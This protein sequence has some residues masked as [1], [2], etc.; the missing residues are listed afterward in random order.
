MNKNKSGFLHLLPLILIGVLIA[1]VGGYFWYQQNLNKVLV[2]EP[3]PAPIIS[4]IPTSS[5]EIVINTDDWKTFMGEGFSFKYPQRFS[6]VSDDQ[7]VD[8]STVVK[9]TDKP[10]D[11][12]KV[13]VVN[14]ERQTFDRYIQKEKDDFDNGFRPAE[15]SSADAEE[16]DINGNK[17]VLLPTDMD[18][19]LLYIYSETQNKVVI[20]DLTL[21]T[22]KFADEFET[23]TT[24]F[25]FD[26]QTS[27]TCPT[28]EWVNCLPGPGPVKAECNSEFLS[29][30]ETNCPSLKGAAY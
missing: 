20:L 1:G 5:S 29:W 23:L 2:A 3:T 19:Y 6:L 14:L 25:M 9:N 30:V 4:P 7:I 16:M 12:I 27:Y 11:N 24:T 8:N 10:S 18:K 21:W 13:S 26:N 28:S 22:E 15:L 17:A